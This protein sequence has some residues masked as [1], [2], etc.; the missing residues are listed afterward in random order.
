MFTATTRQHVSLGVALVTL[1]LPPST[2][3]QIISCFIATLK[4][5]SP[6]NIHNIHSSPNY[7]LR[8]RS[9]IRRLFKFA[10][11]SR[12][13]RLKLGW[14]IKSQSFVN[15][16]ISTYRRLRVFLER[17]IGRIGD[18]CFSMDRHRALMGW[19]NSSYV[20]NLDWATVQ[21]IYRDSIFIKTTCYCVESVIVTHT[22]CEISQNK[23]SFHAIP[24]TPNLQLGASILNIQHLA[25]GLGEEIVTVLSFLFG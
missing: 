13:F 4:M 10:Q 17:S 22:D 11:S 15:D 1:L 3:S 23:S 9:P 21:L 7:P 14:D 18:K 19:C 16:F 5:A 8:G 6:G 12:L 24:K 25:V 20:P 2:L